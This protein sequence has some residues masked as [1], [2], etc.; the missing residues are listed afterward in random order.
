MA[1]DNL[2]GKGVWG[3]MDAHTHT[4]INKV[5]IAKGLSH[6]VHLKLSQPCG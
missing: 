2:D 4:Y 3:R 6:A 5:E 1:C